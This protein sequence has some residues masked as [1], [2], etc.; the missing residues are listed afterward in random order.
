MARPR[1]LLALLCVPVT[2]LPVVLTPSQAAP[3]RVAEFVARC[4]LSHRAPDDP[5]VFP[6]RPGAAHMHDFYGN[7]RTSARSSLQRGR[8]TC[9]PAA[10]RAAY[11]FPTLYR[12]GKA[13]R[14][15]R[16]TFYYVT[17]HEDPA[18]V[19]SLPQGLRIIA[20]DARATRP[21]HPVV[22]EWACLGAGIESD[23][24]MVTCPDGADLEL[25]L[26]FPD[27]WNGRDLDSRDHRSHMA[28]SRADRCP[29]SHPVP[30]AELKFKLTY[31]IAGGKGVRL[32]SGPGYT[33]HGDFVNTWDQRE[34][35][36]RVSRCLRRVI[37]CGEDGRPLE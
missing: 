5:I 9:D 21:L 32:S 3:V 26:R 31:P 37:K 8:T 4:D 20:G 33:A 15:R 1:V 28:Y 7:R 10:D 22:A 12:N 29:G 34:L 23:P 11:W 18:K 2:L 19:R 14:P 16:A 25:H 27:C 13:V 30:V 6:G 24:T 35:N 17:S 36:R